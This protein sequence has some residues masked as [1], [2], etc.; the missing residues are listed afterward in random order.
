MGGALGSG[1]SFE[2]G[3]GVAIGAKM[4]LDRKI[5]NMSVELRHELLEGV[6]RGYVGAPKGRWTLV[7]ENGLRG[8]LDLN[9][10]VI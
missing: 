10:K 2:G 7:T 4:D 8:D 3:S 9:P 5:S 6:R 1:L